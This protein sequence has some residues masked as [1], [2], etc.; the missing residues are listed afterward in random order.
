MALF[1][2]VGFGLL[3]KDQVVG[4]ILVQIV[5]SASPTSQ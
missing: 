5:G 1:G 2:V 4:L 3:L